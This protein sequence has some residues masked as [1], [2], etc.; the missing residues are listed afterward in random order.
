MIR[1]ITLNDDLTR[2]A[3]IIYATD[4]FLFPY[5]FGKGENALEK[6]KALIGLEHNSFSHRYIHGMFDGDTLLGIYIA[7]NAKE[8]SK[9][10]DFTKVFK[11]L[12]AVWLGLKLLP[13]ANLLNPPL[14]NTFYLQNLS[15]HESLRGKGTGK[16]LLKDFYEK[17]LEKGHDTVSLDVALDN[18]GAMRLYLKEGFQL[19]KKRKLL[20][21]FP[22]MYYCEKKIQY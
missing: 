11:G 19:I 6:I 10:E 17:A 7:Y 14:K 16:A 13:I 9:D 5:I 15:V 12:K 20:G 3:E 8:K 18:D 2:V 4:P 22:M 21:L 1:P